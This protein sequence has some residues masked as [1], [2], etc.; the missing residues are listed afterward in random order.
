MARV[1]A[2][3]IRSKR[4]K[5]PSTATAARRSH[6]TISL[7]SVNN[8]VSKLETSVEVLGNRMTVMAEDITAVGQQQSNFHQEWRD[9]KKREDEKVQSRQITI[10]AA[11]GIAFGMITSMA[12]LAGVG[13]FIIDSKIVTA[14]L[15]LAGRQD[16]LVESLRAL[17]DGLER[18]QQAISNTNTLSS[19][20]RTV[21][22]RHEVVLDNVLTRLRMA[23]DQIIRNEERLKA[24]DREV[25]LWDRIKANRTN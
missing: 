4:S 8:R 25:L 15:P 12:V 23:N 5:M 2:A 19:A 3:D 16:N 13:N 11:F 10:P 24:L 6:D 17:R 18:S 9:Q 20:D 14:T 22:G 21:I 7:S 1:N